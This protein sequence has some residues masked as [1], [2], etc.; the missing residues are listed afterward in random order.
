M[1]NMMKLLIGVLVVSTVLI[2]CKKDDDN[3]KETKNFLKI[4]ETE[5]DLSAG[6]LENYGTGDKGWYNGYNTDLTLYSKG[7]SME[8]DGND[9][10]MVGKG[11]LIYFEMFSTAGNVLDN[12]EYTFTS[13]DVCPIGTFDE[14][15]YVINFDYENFVFESY[16]DIENGKVTVSV[17][18]SEYSITIN[19]TDKKG[20]KVT[21]FYKGTLR[22]F[23]MTKGKKSASGEP[24]KIKDKLLRK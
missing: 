5:Y 12:K 10:G 15:D 21:G 16:A 23:D 2:S 17:K 18:G 3:E 11:H 20:K 4:G 19:C 7:L 6:I 24:T 9:Y 14:A 8:L 22:Y 13:A 1:K